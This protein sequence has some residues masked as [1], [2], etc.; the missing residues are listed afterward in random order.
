MR[1]WL[2]DVALR[3]LGPRLAVALLGAVV[4]FLADA[5]LLGGQLSDALLRLLGP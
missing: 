4:G 5:G 2:T 3:I 1:E